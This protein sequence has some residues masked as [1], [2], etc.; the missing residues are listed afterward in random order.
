MS[1]S[2]WSKVIEDPNEYKAMVM[3]LLAEN[4]NEL[5]QEVHRMILNGEIGSELD[6]KLRSLGTVVPYNI[7]IPL[8]RE[9]L[10]LTIMSDEECVTHLTT[11][12]G[13]LTDSDKA[14]VD[15]IIG[16]MN[17]E[18]LDESIVPEIDLLIMME[19]LP[20]DKIY[21]VYNCVDYINES[22]EFT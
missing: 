16:F 13:Y 9:Q 20:T 5:C 6:M 15:K 10:G 11:L 3:E 7:L 14:V 17:D 18:E 21:I 22:S 4:Q 8:L 1:D 12:K 19:Q 2:D